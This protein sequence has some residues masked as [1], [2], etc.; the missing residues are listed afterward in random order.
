MDLSKAFDSIPHDLI[1][2][3]LYAYGFDFEALK[4]ILS[5]LTDREQATRLNSIYS[6]F[7]L[8]LFIYEKGFP[9]KITK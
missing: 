8:I 2:A 9:Y 7:Q 6:A 3:K 5:Y 1:I 4:L